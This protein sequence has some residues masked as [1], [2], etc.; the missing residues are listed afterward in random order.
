VPI[1]APTASSVDCFWPVVPVWAW[2]GGSITERRPWRQSIRYSPAVTCQGAGGWGP[3][4]EK[5][6]DRMRTLQGQS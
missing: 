6:S 1:K 4:A 2:G 5:S 3:R